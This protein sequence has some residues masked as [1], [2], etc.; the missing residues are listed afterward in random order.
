MTKYHRSSFWPERPACSP[1]CT[2]FAIKRLVSVVWKIAVKPSDLFGPFLVRRFVNPRTLLGT[3]A[4]SGFE[5]GRTVLLLEQVG[6]RFVGEFLKIH[7]AI[8]RENIDC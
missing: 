6:E 7:H 4:Q 8:A 5:I 3:F 2:R 1:I